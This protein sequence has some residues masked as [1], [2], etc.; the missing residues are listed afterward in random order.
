[1][2]YYAV[3]WAYKL[4]PGSKGFEDD[5]K[6]LRLLAEKHEGDPLLSLWPTADGYEV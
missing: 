2:Y 3:E 1:M 5:A 6:Q 4:F